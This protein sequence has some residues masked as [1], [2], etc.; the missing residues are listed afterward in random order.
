MS[1]LRMT[2]LISSLMLMLFTVWQ[3]THRRFRRGDLL[4]GLA[5][6]G[7]LL[8]VSLHPP[9]ANDLKILL[10][11]ETRPMALA[12]AGNIVLFG[13]FLYVLRDLSETRSAMSELIR[14]LARV[15]HEKMHGMDPHPGI[16]VI[17]PAFN[18]ERNLHN[19]LPRLPRE[20]CGEA[21]QAIVIVDGSRDR[22]VAVANQYAVPVAMHPLNRGQGDALRTGFELALQKGASIVVTMDA[23]GQHDP[24]ELD[25]LITP[26]LANEADYV[27]G[28]R[29]LG[30]YADRGGA[31]HVGI[32]GFSWL[33][34][35][36]SG[37]RITDSTNGYRAIRA[38]HLGLLDLRENKFNAP[39]LIMEAVNKGLRIREVPVT[40]Q[41]RY[42]GESKK[43]RSWRYPLGFAL[44]IL[45]TW[46]RS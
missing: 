29:F 18:E 4:I 10:Q 11:A 44:V 31:R 7:S 30:A 33:I 32:V 26:I 25:R 28:S 23:D 13:L 34:S 45:R 46:L 6:A 14:A 39:E 43:P 8:A 20:V 38:T 41:S 21:V 17:I 35:L 15:E 37:V 9:V 16:L 1:D 40:I 27:M 22:S 3:Y 24:N 42:E 5:I 19:L 2:G 12:I 36:L